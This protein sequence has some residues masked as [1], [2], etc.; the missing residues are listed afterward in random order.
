M[1]RMSRK[2]KKAEGEGRI[3]PKSILGTR[4]ELNQSYGYNIASHFCER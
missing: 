3:N 4:S 1:S 2:V